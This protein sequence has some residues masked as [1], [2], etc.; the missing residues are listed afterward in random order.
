M[1]KLKAAAGIITIILYTIVHAH[2]Q[3]QEL[4][5]ITLE[6]ILIQGVFYQKTVS[7]V[8]W[9]QNGR[10]YT[11]QRYDAARDSDLIVKYDIATGETVET[12]LDSRKIRLPE[13]RPFSFDSYE[14]SPD[15]SM[16][17][18]ASGEEAIYRRSTKADFYLYDPASDKLTKLNR[19]EKVSY[20]TF[21]PDGKKV[22]FVEGNNLY[23][24]DLN[25]ME[26][27]QVTDDGQKNRIINGS[28]DWVYEEEF[29]FAKAFFWSPDSRKLAFYKFDESAVTEYNMQLWGGLYPDDYKFKYPK[30]GEQNASVQI[31]IYHLDDGATRRVDLPSGGD[32][33][34]PRVQWTADPDI[35]SVVT[36][37]RLQNQLEIHHATAASGKT[38]RVVRETSDTYIDINFNDKL[39]YL[40]DNS[41]F[42]RT[43]EKDGF[44]HIYYHTMKGKLIRQIT[45]GEWEVDQ[46]Y[47]IDEANRLIYYT[48]TEVSPLERH[49]Y[50]VTLEGSNKKRLSQKAGVN[51]AEFS[52]D[53]RYFMHFHSSVDQPNQ[54]R[55]RQ[56]PSGREV[57]VLEDNKELQRLVKKFAFGEK[58][59]F[60]FETADNIRLNGFLIKPHDFDPQKEYPVLMYVYG[61]PGSQE[62]MN[63][64][65]GVSDLW[66]NYLTQ[67][68]FIV[69]CVD[70]RGT[71]GRGK[72]FRDVTYARLGKL[73][74]EDQVAGAKYLA[75]LA[76]VDEAR[77]GIWGWSYGGYMSS[78][79]VLLGA[80]VFKAA[81]A[82]AP[83]TSWR[84]YDTIYTERYLKTPQLNPGGYDDYSPIT[85]AVKLE[86]PY[87]I[88]HGT[89]DDNV[90][91]QNTVEMIDA[92]IAAN[93]QFDSF[94][95]P[96]RAHGIGD[97]FAR[98]HLYQLMTDFLQENL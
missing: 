95:Y 89:G 7:G 86:D 50:Q 53:F 66:H 17:L 22:A 6:D 63:S 42:L 45:H 52:P 44:K 72:A 19:D 90:H 24:I 55:L 77:I 87:L 28:A 34:T 59:F 36:M 93:K 25:A 32:V 4:R 73:E 15:E 37:N 70:N 40:K 9:M 65:G 79:A 62:V 92:L 94:I 67:R 5:Q 81:I 39:I 16:I 78:L 88:I 49:I 85:H 54:V 43:S 56:A 41:G 74:T 71:G 26:T 98:Y 23:F 21:S 3:A 75:S 60:Q 58:E 48:S 83:V 82:V 51:K 2:V 69:A 10:Y 11:A 18:L 47:G 20:A 76:Y 13:N 80:D 57:S 27:V 12:L 1:S 61:G 46:F 91:F 33:Y 96:N 97:V 31:M 14:M 8:N 38:N 30:A 29:A 35:L 64:W 68:G 84:F